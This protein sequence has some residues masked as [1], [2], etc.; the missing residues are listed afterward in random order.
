MNPAVLYRAAVLPGIR[1]LILV[2][3]ALAAFA[4]ALIMYV[5]IAA[6]LD[7]QSGDAKPIAVIGA[8]VILALLIGV[9]I[10]IVRGAWSAFIVT[11]AGITVRGIART[12]H[13]PWSDIAVIQVDPRHMHRGEAVV[14]RRDGTR[15]GSGVTAARYAIRR[16][17][18][19][20]DHGPQ[21]LHPAR[22]VRAAIDAHQRY[23]RG[24]FG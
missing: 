14:V 20:F 9:L 4:P 18:S 3:A 11:T 6:A 7:A 22:P 2:L 21:L 5:L 8:F 1:V 19:T 24:E 10:V 15:I 16:G 12:V 23:L 13:V 17:E